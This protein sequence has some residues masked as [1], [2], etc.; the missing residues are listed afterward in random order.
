YD[1]VEN[2]ARVAPIGALS[3]ERIPL[4]EGRFRLDL[5]YRKRAANGTLRFQGQV[6]CVDDALATP[7]WWQIESAAHD[8]SGAAISET[9]QVEKGSASDE[10]LLLNMGAGD[11]KVPV[12]GAWAMSWALFEAVQRLPGDTGRVYRFTLIDRLSGQ[13]KP[14]QTLAFRGLANVRL[15]GRMVWGEE[16]EPL[17]VGTRYRP[18]ARREGASMVRLRVFEH[19]G[20]GVLPTTYWVG[21]RGRLLFVLSGLTAF[22]YNPRAVV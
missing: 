18:V 20:E 19:F 21:E 17:E 3:V 11:R 2:A 9:R 6:Q 7:V 16:A 13:V 12:R 8:A 14:N 10:G 22:L 4:A 5:A 15:G 1:L